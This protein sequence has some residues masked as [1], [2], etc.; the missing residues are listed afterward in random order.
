MV[1]DLQGHTTKTSYLV[2]SPLKAKRGSR[3]SQPFL[4]NLTGTRYRFMYCRYVLVLPCT[5]TVHLACAEVWPEFFAS[6]APVPYIA[7]NVR[8][9]GFQRCIARQQLRSSRPH[10][11]TSHPSTVPVICPVAVVMT[12]CMTGVTGLTTS[13]DGWKSAVDL[14]RPARMKEFFDAVFG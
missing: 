13:Q 9:S 8:L 1:F 14:R 11:A 4:D 2:I 6:A 7:G 12:A 3:R 5:G 10:F